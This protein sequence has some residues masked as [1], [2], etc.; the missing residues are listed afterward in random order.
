MSKIKLVYS[1]SKFPVS[2]HCLKILNFDNSNSRNAP[3]FLSN[4][5][6]NIEVSDMVQTFRNSRYIIRVYVKSSMSR[7]RVYAVSI[8]IHRRGTTEE[9]YT[10]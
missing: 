2:V 8:T 5:M 9:C 4:K 7:L 1:G 3:F 6:T 10:C